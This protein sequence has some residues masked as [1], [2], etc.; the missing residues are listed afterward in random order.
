MLI[1]PS[2]ETVVDRKDGI[3]TKTNCETTKHP[4]TKPSQSYPSTVGD[5]CMSIDHGTVMNLQGHAFKTPCITPCE[6]KALYSYDFTPC[7]T[8]TPHC[9]KK[10]FIDIGLRG[11]YG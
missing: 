3:Q 2:F 6:L 11:L 9:V 10:V 1:T 7:G 8:I 4:T 5:M